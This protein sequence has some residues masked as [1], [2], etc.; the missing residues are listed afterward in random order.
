M[1]PD[2]RY[3]LPVKQYRWYVLFFNALMLGALGTALG[4]TLWNARG[5]ISWR[6]AVVVPLLLTQMGLYLWLL[7]TGKGWPLPRRRLVVY[8]CCCLA[9]WAIEFWLVPEIFWVVFA[10]IGQMFGLLPPVYGIAGAVLAGAIIFA[11]NAGWELS[12]LDAGPMLQTAAIWAS[13]VLFMLYI[14]HLTRASEERG[15]LIAELEAAKEELEAAQQREAEL[16]VLRERERL[17]RDLHDTL[18]HA[19]V[20]LS[21]Q[22][23]AIQRLYRLDPD[24]ASVQ[25]D[26][27]KALTRASMDDLR[28]S[29]AGLRAPGLGDRSLS[30]AL[31]ELCAELGSRSGIQV[32]CQISEAAD[33]LG[34]VL[35]EALWRIA[36]EALTNVEKHARARH[37]SVSLACESRS[38]ILRISDDGIG[39]R[40]GAEPSPN[41]FG[42]RGM[43]ERVE[44]LGGTLA[45]SDASGGT[46]VEAKLPIITLVNGPRPV[47]RRSPADGKTEG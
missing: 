47:Q 35:A 42:L 28:R 5:G 15:R 2:R 3:P 7:A 25:V 9:I 6:E 38:V 12:N 21:V 10:Y 36:Q 14:N 46:R 33:G 37:A 24:Q 45:L 23:E 4:M 40:G 8:F 20:A 22:L 26:E 29:V 39:L 1:E 19:L 11:G 34:T 18:G 30:V 43:R 16:A 44:G 17:A 32:D 27:M 31:R 41:S 13:I